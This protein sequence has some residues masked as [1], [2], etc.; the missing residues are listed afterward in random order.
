[1]F[2]DQEVGPLWKELLVGR[3]YILNSNN[4]DFKGSNGSY[5]YEVG[6]P[7]GCLSSW[8]ML[9][10]SHHMIVQVAARRAGFKG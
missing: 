2:N 8:G 9:A 3:E 5:K 10:L 4:P 7:M 1:L 6:Q